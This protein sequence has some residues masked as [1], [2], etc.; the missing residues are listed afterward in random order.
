MD[1]EVVEEYKF[2]YTSSGWTNQVLGLEWI[3]NCIAHTAKQVKGGYRLLI[4]DG[5]DSE[6]NMELIESCL[7][8]NIVA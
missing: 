5:H 8:S 3:K 1:A 7:A 6:V 4:V 2:A